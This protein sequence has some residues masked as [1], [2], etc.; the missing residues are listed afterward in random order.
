[1]D[2]SE[3]AKLTVSIRHIERFSKS[4]IPLYNFKDLDTAGRKTRSRRRAQA[5]AK[6]R[7]FH[8]NAIIS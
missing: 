8:A 5:I 4:E 7:T 2:T 6:R 3:K 1:M